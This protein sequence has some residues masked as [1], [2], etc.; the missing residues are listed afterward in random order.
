MS[1]FRLSSLLNFLS[2][3]VM[4]GFTTYVFFVLLLV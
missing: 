4:T 1:F 2:F 3:S